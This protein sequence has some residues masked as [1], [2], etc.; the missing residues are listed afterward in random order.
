MPKPIKKMGMNE[1]QEAELLRGKIEEALTIPEI[2]G[3]NKKEGEHPRVL[4]EHVFF[5]GKFEKEDAGVV[6]RAIWFCT[7]G[8]FGDFRDEGAIEGWATKVAEEIAQTERNEEVAA[9]DGVVQ[10]PI[11]V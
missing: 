3:K 9:V 11:Q 4:K 8:K 6:L 7:G 10:T 5:E 1:V 2:K